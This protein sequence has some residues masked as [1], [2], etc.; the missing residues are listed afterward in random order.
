MPLRVWR[1]CKAKHAGTPLDGEGARLYGGRWNP[2]GTALVYASSSLALAQLELLVHLD[3]ADAP[4]DMVAVELEIP[5]RTTVEAID[6]AS[7]PRHWRRH[8]APS[9]LA[10]IGAEW[11]ASL[12]TVALRVP[13]AIVPRE[14]NC[15]LNPAHRDIGR[16]TVVARE[17]VVFDD[18][19]FEPRR[20]SA[21]PRKKR[22]RRA[23][24]GS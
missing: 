20:K 10:K 13:S 19:L 11:A 4:A 24:P 6:P 22:A 8:P 7:L 14:F 23:S 5:G 1:L 12:R 17:K 16:I 2:P 15:L 3:R 18:R 9:A 21:K